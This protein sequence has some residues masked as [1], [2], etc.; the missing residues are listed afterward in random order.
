MRPFFWSQVL[1]FQSS[2]LFSSPLRIAN[3][4]AL[5]LVGELGG[6]FTHTTAD[7]LLLAFATWN[8]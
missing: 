7:E 1:C 6:K 3:G 4:E 5:L 2:S 8:R